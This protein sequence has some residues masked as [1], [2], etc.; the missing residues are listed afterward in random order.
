MEIHEHR[1]RHISA[2]VHQRLHQIDLVFADDRLEI[3]PH[4]GVLQTGFHSR[5]EVEEVDILFRRLVHER[6]Q[7]SADDVF[8][9]RGRGRTDGY[10]EFVDAGE[11]PD[12]FGRMDKLDVVVLDQHVLAELLLTPREVNL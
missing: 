3:R 6:E 8:V 10:G 5:D 2:D 12:W 1:L 9:R 11:G 7:R 4:F